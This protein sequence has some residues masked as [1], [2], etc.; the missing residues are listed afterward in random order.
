MVVTRC[1]VRGKP[2]RSCLMRRGVRLTW[3]LA[4][5]LWVLGAGG[6]QVRSVRGT[7]TDQNGHVLAGAVVQ[8]QDRTTSQVRSYVTQEDGS[9]H[10]ED[11][12]S[13]LSYHLRAN[14]AG[15][16]SR[17]KILSK[18]DSDQVAVIDLKIQVSK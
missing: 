12:F 2:R 7:V 14:Y 5:V 9:Y 13:D 4:L 11:L 6:Q 17:S 18:F 10:F 8:I 15:V 16:S 1:S 3:V